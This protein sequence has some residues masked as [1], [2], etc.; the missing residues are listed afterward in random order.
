MPDEMPADPQAEPVNSPRAADPHDPGTSVGPDG[1]GPYAA[2]AQAPVPSAAR[3]YGG[4]P[5][6][7]GPY[8]E[9]APPD[10]ARLR[11]AQRRLSVTE[12]RL[13]RAE[14]RLASLESSTALR[15]G[16]LLVHVARRPARIPLLPRDLYRLWRGRGTRPAPPPTPRPTATAVYEEERL[17]VSGPAHPAPALGPGRPL[18][19]GVLTD[20]AAG[21]LAAVADVVPLSPHDAAQ[22]LAR[23]EPDV[24]IV[25][26]AACAGGP[27]FGL[28]DPTAT[29]LEVRLAEALRGTTAP[30]VLLA[31]APCPPT[32][33]G[34]HWHHVSRTSLGTDLHTFHPLPASG[35]SAG[36]QTGSGE[37][38]QG[39]AGP[40][41]APSAEP[42]RGHGKGGGAEPPSTTPARREVAGVPAEVPHVPTVQL[43]VPT[44]D[45]L[46]ASSG[47][48][49]G[50]RGPSPSPESGPSAGGVERRAEPL[51][52]WPED[53]RAPLSLRRMREEVLAVLPVVDGSGAAGSRRAS[54]MRAHHAVLAGTPDAVAEALACGAWVV[55]PEH[56]VPDDLRPHVHIASDADQAAKHLAAME[57][58]RPYAEAQAALRAVFTHH[59]IPSRL[60]TLLTTA[61]TAA[62]APAS[63]ASPRN[64]P[65]PGSPSEGPEPSGTTE[66]GPGSPGPTVPRALSVGER[67]LARRRVAVLTRARTEDAPWP[68]A[69]TEDPPRPTPA[70]VPVEVVADPGLT[71]AELAARA[72]TPWV[73][74]G[75]SG[76]C[77]LDTLAD[78]VC[79]AE[80]GRADAVGYDPR[81]AAP[82]YVTA[83]APVLARRELVASGDPPA[84]WFARYG[85]RLLALPTPAPAGEG[86]E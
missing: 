41:P 43:S 23:T 57:S 42:G 2:G 73:A 67:A 44:G 12:A 34:H 14:A 78:L 22:I 31:D 9:D 68:G 18:V 33:A 28:G 81:A 63:P 50:L 25:Q 61:H 86:T 5:Y 8:G 38:E 62:T 69:G 66:G 51:M 71:W 20:A 30:R 58:P 17:L 6:G 29:D 45:S 75:D 52:V 36:V 13:R 49:R 70:A 47:T 76:V 46:T 24:I 27:W 1:A 11:A 16:R 4:G 85:A 82:G 83:L 37:G 65:D 48:G 40:A 10:T 54:L 72:T 60:A 79:A 39:G 21:A 15:A 56:A 7:G 55:A 26:T 59:S 64:A 84:T 80:Y 53:L 74:Y 35:P 32:L 77:T 19:A 3:L